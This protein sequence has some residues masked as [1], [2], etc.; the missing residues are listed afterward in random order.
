MKKSVSLGAVLAAA[1]TGCLPH[2]YSM[3]KRLV[4]AEEFT[5]SVKNGQV[6][7]YS[8]FRVEE[9]AEK[10][11]LA[12]VASPAAPAAPDSGYGLA[13]ASLESPQAAV[14]QPAVNAGPAAQGDPRYVSQGLTLRK[15]VGAPQTEFVN[16]GDVAGAELP[17]EAYRQPPRPPEFP[18]LPPGSSSPYATGQMTHNPSLW[19]D[20]AQGSSLFTDFRAFQAMDIITIVVN[21]SSTGTKKTKTDSSSDY[22]ILAGITELFGIETKSWSSNNE[23]LDPATLI[24]AATEQSFEGEGET[25][26]EG[27]MK[28]QVSAVIMEVLPNGLMRVEGTKI[29]S[30]DNEEEVMVI[31]GLV[32]SRDITSQNQ[33]DSNRIANMRIDFYGRG[34][35]AQHQQPGWGARFIA[36]IWPF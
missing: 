26:R 5:R 7:D 32:R 10:A 17:K 21:E 31:S 25:K 20:E 14:G 8:I 34:V 3:E 28:A 6:A 35:L 11:R 18:Q 9:E 36:A 1:C 16:D 15:S 22:S 19:P 29:V 30:V 2:D 13:R 27:A 23:S 12:R 33:V 24:S 4:P